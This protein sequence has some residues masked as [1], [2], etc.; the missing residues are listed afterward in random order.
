MRKKIVTILIT[1]ALGASMAAGQTVMAVE[2]EE[3]T[4]AAADNSTEDEK[5]EELKTIGEEKADIFKVKIKNL[6]GKVI[7]GV[8]VKNEKDDKYPDNFLKDGDKFEKG[9]ER[10]LW[11]DPAVKDEKETDKASEQDAKQEKEIPKYN[12][13][14]TFEDETTAEIHTFPFGDTEAVELKLEGETAYLVFDSISLKESVNTLKTEQALA[15]KPAETQTQA[16]TQSYSQNYDY[17]YDYSNDYDYDNDDYSYDYDG[18]TDDSG[19]S[20]DSESDYEGDAGSDDT[21]AGDGCLDNG[22]LN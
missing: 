10:I 18:D 12:L 9:E 7:T 4:E 17:D 6:T 13:Q 21:G 16:G 19:D 14:F 2:S 3:T 5:E 15:P 11:F 8:S 1:A 22:L 20:G